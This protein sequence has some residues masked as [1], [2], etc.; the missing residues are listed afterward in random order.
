[1]WAN[2]C[3]PGTWKTKVEGPRTQGH[4]QPY[5]KPKSSIWAAR[6]PTCLK[7][8]ETGEEKNGGF[9]WGIA[10]CPFKFLI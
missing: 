10:L 6:D 7:E 9:D 3:H 2:V 5:N 8:E 1:M 4:L